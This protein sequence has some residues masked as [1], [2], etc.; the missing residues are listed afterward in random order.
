MHCISAQHPDYPPDLRDICD[1]KLQKYT[2]THTNRLMFAPLATFSLPDK[3]VMGSHCT[4]MTQYIIITRRLPHQAQPC[5]KAKREDSITGVPTLLLAFSSKTSTTYIKSYTRFLGV[6]LL[7]AQLMNNG[8]KMSKSLCSS[9]PLSKVRQ[10]H[11]TLA[12][13]FTAGLDR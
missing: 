5:V 12:C 2:Y 1:V 13:D 8:I 9:V 10:P 4:G 11:I 7:K 6:L 3:R